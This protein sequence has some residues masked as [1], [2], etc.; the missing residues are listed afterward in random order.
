MPI[1]GNKKGAGTFNC[2]RKWV[3]KF[4]YVLFF[5]LLHVGFAPVQDGNS[6]FATHDSNLSRGPGIVLITSQVLG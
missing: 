3:S 2:C 4:L 6:S 5:I 1:M